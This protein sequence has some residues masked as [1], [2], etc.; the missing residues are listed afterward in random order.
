MLTIRAEQWEVLEKAEEAKFLTFLTLTLAQL[1]PKIAAMIR[2]ESNSVEKK[3]L[4]EDFV[5]ECVQTAEEIDFE[6]DVDIAIFTALV[7]LADEYGATFPGLFNQIFHMVSREGSPRLRIAMIE[8]RFVE[9]AD[10]QPE[11]CPL[12]EV[13]TATREAFS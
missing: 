10:Q 12:M 5:M 4:F 6:D 7:M 13:L 9:M 8:E 3:D 2:S 1:L 11:I